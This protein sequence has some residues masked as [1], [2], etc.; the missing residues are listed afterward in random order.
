MSRRV[1]ALTLMLTG[2]LAALVVSAQEAQPGAADERVFR[3][4][5]VLPAN[6][7]LDAPVESRVTVIFN[8]PV[9]P[10]VVGMDPA[11]LPNP[12]T[13][14]P[15]VAGSGEWLNTSIYVFT[16]SAEAPLG[17]GVEYTVSVGRLE[18]FDGVALE[19]FSWSFRT[20]PPQVTQV[21]PEPQASSVLLEGPIRITFN[22]PMDQASVEAAFSLTPDGQPDAPVLG[23]FD[24]PQTSVMTFTPN[25]LLNLDTFYRV[26]LDGEVARAANDGALL[27]ADAP[28]WTFLTVPRP[29]IVS[30]SPLDGG[31]GIGQ[32]EGVVL[33]FASPMAEDSITGRIRISPE[34]GMGT[35]GFY[36]TFNDSYRL[37]FFAEPSTTYTVTI[38]PGMQDIY[39]NTIDTGRTFSYT[40][41]PLDPEVRLQTPGQIG[42]YDGLRDTTEL[43][44][45]YRNVET[46]DLALY[47]ADLGDFA[48]IITLD[49]FG[50]SRAYRPVEGELRREWSVD[51]STLPE[52]I[53]RYDLL[54]LGAAG[55]VGNSCPGAPPSRLQPGDIGSVIVEPNPLRARSEPPNGE[56]VELMYRDYR[57]SVVDG[58]RCIEGIPW[59]QITLR[60]DSLAWIAESV[61]G[62]Y[63]VGVA[64][65]AEQ[66]AVE[67]TEADGG[68]LAP[69]LYFLT[70]QA[71]ELP[72]EDAR[73]FMIVGT[74]NITLKVGQREMVAWVTNVHTGEP[75]AGIPVNFIGTE[76]SMFGNAVTDETGLAR[77]ALG[78]GEGRIALAYVDTPDQFGIGF[79]G[80]TRGIESYQLGVSYD[81]SPDPY[82]AYVYTDRPV[83]RPDQPVYYRGVIRDKVDVAYTPPNVD[84]VIAR[85]FDSNN[86]VIHEETLPLDEF[87]AFAAT[88]ELAED[89]GLGG[90]RLS[91]YNPASPDG[92]PFTSIRFDV[93]EYR[94][95]EY[96]VEVVSQ[97]AEVVQGADLLAAVDA[98]YFF[99]GPVG[100]A[101]LE[102]R[103]ETRDYGFR[104]EG[105]GRYSFFDN[106]P[107][108]FNFLY[109]FGYEIE[110]GRATTDERGN[111]LVEVPTFLENDNGFGAE[112]TI[113]A[114]VFDETGV[115]VSGRSTAV[116]HPSEVYV[117]VG[118]ENYI[119]QAGEQVDMN[120][121][122]V[123]WDSAPVAEQFLD[124]RL[125]RW[126][127]ATV[128]EV[129]GNG[130]TVFTE[131]L[132]TVVLDEVVIVTEADGTADYDFTPEQGGVYKVVVTTRDDN[133]NE[134]TASQIVWVSGTEYVQW[135]VNN[136]NTL[137]I[138]TDADDYNIGDTAR[139][140]VTS[141]FQGTTE[142]LITV[143][144]DGVITSEHLTLDSNSLVYDLPITEDFA[145]NVFVGVMLVKGVD[146]T[147]PIA[148]FRYGM[149]QLNVETSRKVVNIEITPDR[150]IA[151][152]Q[153]TVTYTVRTTNYAGEPVAAQ[154]GVAL[155][156]L[157]SLS[158]APPNSGPILTN[159]Y[160]IQSLSVVTSTPLTINTDE[161]TAF[162]R[163]VVKGGG[164]GGGGGGGVFEIRAEFVDTPYWNA[165]LETDAEG[166]AEFEVVLP[167]NLTTWRLDARAITLSVDSPFLVGQDTFDLISTRPL[168]VRPVTPRFFV[169][170]DQVTLAAV[171]NNNTGA[172]QD[173]TAFMEIEGVT[174]AGENEQTETVPADGRARFE[175]EVVVEDVDAVDVTFF[176]TNA[177]GEFT[178]ASRPA[179]GL[180]DDRLLPVYRFAV[181]ETVG[182]AGTVTPGDG[183]ITEG[184]VLPD[185]LADGGLLSLNVNTSLAAVTVD[186]LDYLENFPHQCTEQTVSRFLPNIITTSAL[187]ELGIVAPELRANLDEQVSAGLQILFNRQNIDGGWGWFSRDNSNTLVTAYVLVG[188]QEAQDAGFAVTP[189]ALMGGQ[190]FLR[191]EMNS[192]LFNTPAL[193]GQN[194]QYNREAFILF[195]LSRAGFYDM[196]RMAN[197]YEA[198]ARLNPL[199]KAYL[200]LALD[201]A[202]QDNVGD[203]RIDTLI[204]EILNSAS[205]SAAGTFWSSDDPFNWTTDTRATAVGLEALVTTQPDSELIPNV[206]RYLVSARTA[207]RW[208]TTQE[209]AWAVMALSD[210]MVASD[211]LN[212]DYDFTVSVNDEAVLEDS[213][214]RDA[215]N[216]TRSLVLDVADLLQDE[217]NRLTFAVDGD[218]GTLYYSAFLEASLPVDEVEPLDSGIIVARRYVGADGE[219]IDAANVGDIVE[220]RITVVAPEDLHYVMIEDPV[221]AGLEPI[222]PNL[223][224]S[225]Q[226]GTRPELENL[227]NGWGWWWFSNT[228]FRDEK[229]VLYSTFLPAGTYEYRYTARATVPGTYKVIPTTAEEFYFPDVYG[230]G[231]GSVFTVNAVE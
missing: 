89:A 12:L 65:A 99:G 214:S 167:D 161:V 186:G 229:A 64:G 25:P 195:A 133:G 127:W 96:Q 102:Y 112:L 145:P 28:E 109:P 1:L 9:V 225:S 8:R 97:Q 105:E 188:L 174:F 63:L 4:T 19:P 15:A 76:Q 67:V 170:G 111:A 142:A 34:P 62:E 70:A 216:E 16:P 183:S 221:P 144:R 141:P 211:E 202:D 47:D 23:T 49:P 24:W 51:A 203:A 39:G 215:A 107:Y 6:A 42:F 95:P 197:L 177:D 194:W 100:D 11:D 48:Q 212:A 185:N 88:F 87:G 192:P 176:A 132:R 120:L 93:A 163:D 156:D 17:G 130:D 110:F 226:I 101:Y 77:I 135:R 200:V 171:V 223:V 114:T 155:T 204:T 32:F 227:D 14:T 140:L 231:A 147:N 20:V 117:G 36:S 113:E 3:V 45:S 180:G 56:I 181:R 57:F 10:L 187:D 85:L 159:F 84:S 116:V 61:D 199:G 190:A 150:K 218:D 179:V 168:L 82:G 126:Q 75:L 193:G 72:D 108:D 33:S 206:V 27:G 26:G 59:F 138:V 228:E 143:E 69:G 46:V 92:T 175:W 131:Q 106:D 94:L 121:I 73:H 7:T 146:D 124:V 162:V 41:R 205:T 154:V 18:S 30:T 21:E 80:W 207:D 91:I 172:E 209:T 35:R 74:V 222:D 115:A 139:I 191:D 38:E 104:Y 58:P 136:D 118:T 2:L 78:P 37:N 53:R 208:E 43:Y 129:D 152:P 173:V 31:V 119:N 217:A 158:I 169:V 83:Y 86:E 210:W 148:S 153:E 184:V 213:A 201:M 79:A 149:T 220:V 54:T 196:G 90:Y 125:E 103:V 81:V 5:E 134:T 52:N 166:T 50:V 219:T 122:A 123:G 198:R 137:D 128:Q 44:L 71:R 157:A 29:A 230:R 66:G 160:G 164:G 98:T 189:G 60:D 68:K 22:Q 55:P 151:E 13:F 40:T 224:T 182:T 165:Q 178:D